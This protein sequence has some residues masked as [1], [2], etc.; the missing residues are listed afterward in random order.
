M[1]CTS[2]N[3]PGPGASTRRQATPLPSCE[4]SDL[5]AA[6][7]RPA[8]TVTGRR[9]GLALLAGLL[10]AACSPAEPIGKARIEKGEGLE[11][12][13]F[14]FLER[15]G[16]PFSEKDL[17]GKVWVGSL[18]FTRC[19]TSCIPMCA[20]MYQLQEDFRDEPDFR[21]VATTVDPAYDT[22]EVLGKF[23]KSYDADPDRW[24]FLT[25]TA[26]DIRRFAVEGLR[27][28]WNADDPIV[29]SVDFVLVDRDGRIRDY[30][31]QTQPD[32]MQRMREVIR[33]VLGEKA[34]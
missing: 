10:L 28:P 14:D 2:C 32:R 18:I 6:N 20:E 19:T 4:R 5:E 24:Y 29:H 33:E 16:R 27:I 7:G 12:G 34:P 30:F 8:A 22:A 3:R 25:G 17:K 1:T 13:A 21:I 11:V 9:S 26:E 23:A 15:S 31:R